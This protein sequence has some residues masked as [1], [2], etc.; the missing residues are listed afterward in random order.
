[1]SIKMWTNNDVQSRSTGRRH[2]WIYVERSSSQFYE[3][4]PHDSDEYGILTPSPY[5]YALQ[6]NVDSQPISRRRR[7]GE[8]VMVKE[9]NKDHATPETDTST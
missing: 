4:P 7:T 3:G 2:D 9:E 8:K 6:R 5:A 1:M